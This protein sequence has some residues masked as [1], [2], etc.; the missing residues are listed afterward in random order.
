MKLKIKSVKGLRIGDVFN[1]KGINFIAT[2]FPT[3]NMVCGRKQTPKSG[4]PCN[5]KTSLFNTPTI[6]WMHFKDKR[7]MPNVLN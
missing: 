7:F 3:R 1:V 6:F 4:E 2:E 5:I